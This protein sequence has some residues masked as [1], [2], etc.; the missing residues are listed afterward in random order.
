MRKKN[1]IL[2]FL[3]F[4]TLIS[5]IIY[6]YYYLFIYLKD[7]KGYID[8]NYI[9]GNSI[10]I[11]NS[12]PISDELGI[13]LN[14]SDLN[15]GLYGYSEIE[16]VCH[17]K[18]FLPFNYEILGE[19]VNNDEDNNIEKFI[20]IY[21]TN[22]DND[23]YLTGYNNVIVPVYDDLRDKNNSDNIKIL[24]SGT[25]RHN[26]DVHRYR[27]RMWLSDSY[28][29]NTNSNNFNINISVKKK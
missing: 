3:I 12:L 21:L 19:N 27:I 8:V 7:E 11:S 23:H 24:Y 6:G 15:S 13:K 1:K 5:L 26:K 28:I 17:M 18:S 16:V 20:K 14:N 2:N 29:V 25:C 22:V 10:S 9:N 4:F